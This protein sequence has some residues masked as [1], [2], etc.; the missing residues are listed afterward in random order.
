MTSPVKHTYYTESDCNKLLEAFPEESEVIQPALEAIRNLSKMQKKELP[1][2]GKARNK[3]LGDLRDV[4]ISVMEYDKKIEL[5]RQQIIDKDV[6]EEADETLYTVADCEQLSLLFPDKKDFFNNAKQ[7]MEAVSKR[8][9]E[10][11][12][13]GKKGKA[14]HA[15]RLKELRA[16]VKEYDLQIKGLQ[17]V[18]TPE[19]KVFTIEDQ[20]E[21]VF[22]TQVSTK[23]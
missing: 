10:R 15:N 3:Y 1:P 4:K 2:P 8:E 17:K 7:A 5:I 19:N 21:F 18:V 22:V 14:A 23:S 11:F 13:P 6:E 9:N 12:A 16:K 20:E